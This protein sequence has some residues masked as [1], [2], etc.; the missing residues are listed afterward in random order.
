MTGVQVKTLKLNGTGHDLARTKNIVIAAGGLLLLTLF[1]FVPLV[2]K[3][4][5]ALNLSAKLNGL[6]CIGLLFNGFR[7][8]FVDPDIGRLTIDVPPAVCVLLLAAALFAL[9][10]TAIGVYGAVTD[11]EFRATGIVACA[12]AV[13]S[14]MLY[15]LLIL[16]IG[17]GAQ[18]FF[19]NECLF[20]QTFSIGNGLLFLTALSAALA[21]FHYGIRAS[22]LRALKRYAVFYAM[23]A[24]PLAFM[25]VFYLYPVLLQTVMSFKEYKLSTG[26]W[27][28]SWVGFKN[29]ATIFTSR[30]MLY[31]IGNTIYI[32][33]VKIVI[34]IVLP[35]ILAILLFDL[36][37]SK[38]RKGVQTIVYIPHFFSWVVIYAISYAFLNNEGVLNSVI[39]LFGGQTNDFLTNSRLFV[40]IQAI[41]FGWKEIGWGTI[42]Y[43]AALMGVDTS[44]FDAAKVDGAGPLRRLWHITLPSIRPVIIFTMILSL[45]NILKSAGGEQLMLFYNVAVHDQAMVIDTWLYFRGLIDF[46]YSLGSA[47]SFFQSFI[48]I[49]LVLICN[50]MSKKFT[51]RTIW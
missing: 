18:D 10:L 48:G 26:I 6:K 51:D 14:C 32:S 23:V 44:M 45:G 3:T 21:V 9:A 8:Y 46:E 22:K 4:N 33:L 42:I 43:F 15:V 2:S 5:D 20:Y 38:F 1:L 25:V 40:P 13:Y 16:P 27:N 12:G 30:E 11:R 41:V 34:S 31:V 24:L 47:M 28:S 50:W 29:F 49:I 39:K 36:R 17:V 37:F 35:L 7:Y 19:G